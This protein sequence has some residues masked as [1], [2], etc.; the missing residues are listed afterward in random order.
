MRFT[1]DDR[2]ID[3]VPRDGHKAEFNAWRWARLDEITDLVVDFKRPIYEAITRE[4]AHL[5]R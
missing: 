5:V 3:I 4:F 1:G 2:E